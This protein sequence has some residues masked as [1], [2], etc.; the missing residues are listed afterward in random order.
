[1]DKAVLEEA[2]SRLAAARQERARIAPLPAACCPRSVDEAHAIQ[3]AVALKLD[4]AIGGFKASVPSAPAAD[5]KQQTA[6]AAAAANATKPIMEG[7]RALIFEPT[8]YAS[9]CTF[10]SREAPQCGVEAEIAFRFRC[11]LP[12][13]ATPYSHD[14]IAAVTDAY[15]AIEVVS[16]RFASPEQTTYL[17]RLADSISNGGFVHGA[18]RPDWH[19]LSLAELRVEL[20]V[21]GETIVNQIGGH[22]KGDPFGSVMALVEM[23]RT[24]TGVTAGQF[25]TCGS[26]TGLRYFKPGDVCAVRFE[27]LGSVHLT[28]QP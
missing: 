17:D 28:F 25:V 6:P 21:N 26:H 1:M 13:R 12:P 3:D 14:E 9:P 27:G 8:I 2:A 7:V 24:T 4:A 20:I 23:M 22:P 19:H 18:A 10:P 11:D 16:S 15:P 5:N